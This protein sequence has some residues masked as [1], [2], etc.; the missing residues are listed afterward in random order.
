MLQIRLLIWD[1]DY[2]EMEAYKA[3]SAISTSRELS[4]QLDRIEA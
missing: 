4:S 2:K 1:L 3:V